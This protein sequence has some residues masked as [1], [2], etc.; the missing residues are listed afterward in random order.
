MGASKTPGRALNKAAQHPGPSGA[1]DTDGGGTHTAFGRAGD[2]TVDI[3]ALMRKKKQMLLVPS[4]GLSGG[5]LASS[6]SQ[7]ASLSGGAFGSGNGLDHLAENPVYSPDDSLAKAAS[8]LQSLKALRTSSAR[9]LSSLAGNTAEQPAAAAPLPAPLA[10]Q[11][12]E[13]PQAV[14]EERGPAPAAERR[15]R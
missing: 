1:L 9:P 14:Q 11:P 8:K 4:S 7:Q 5:G 10:P 12:C 6:R 15:L 2:A 13:S 3:G